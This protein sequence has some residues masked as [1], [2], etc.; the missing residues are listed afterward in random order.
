MVPSFPGYSLA[1]FRQALARKDRSGDSIAPFVFHILAMHFALAQNPQL[2]Q[3]FAGLRL[4][5]TSET[6]PEFGSLP[7]TCISTPAGTV[8][9]PDDVI[10]E[11]IELID[12]AQAEEVLDYEAWGNLQDPWLLTAE[13]ATPTS[14][15]A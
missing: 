6:L 15:A 12:P 8:R 14:R 3:L 2:V 10:A 9:P 1:E 7:I 11:L 13:G 4:Q 5:I